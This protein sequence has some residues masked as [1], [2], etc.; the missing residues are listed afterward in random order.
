MATDLEKLFGGYLFIE[1]FLSIAESQD[2]RAL[3]NVGR[4][5]RMVIGVWLFGR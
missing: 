4:L 3:S 5:G 2:Q 1:G